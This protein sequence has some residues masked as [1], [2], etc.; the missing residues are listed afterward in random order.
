MEFVFRAFSLGHA[1]LPADGMQ[2]IPAQ[3]ASTLPRSALRLSATVAKIE[4]GAV[5][6]SDGGELQAPCVVVATEEPTARR[7]L[8]E[9]CVKEDPGCRSTVCLYFA[10]PYAPTREPILMLNG[11][12]DGVINHVAFPSLAQ[13]SYAPAGWTLAS[14]NTIGL[15]DAMGLAC[16]EQVLTELECWFGWSVRTWRHLQTYRIPYALPNQSPA[17]LAAWK[18]DMN[19]GNGLYLCGDYCETASI[20]GAI[21]SGL[22]VASQIQRDLASTNSV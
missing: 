10:V 8:G 16:V 11:N 19:R 18:V 15:S 7:L 6:L 2:A 13:S 3:I 21:Q 9:T 22:K 5:R 4:P 1:A 12:G 17:A 20:E 14:V